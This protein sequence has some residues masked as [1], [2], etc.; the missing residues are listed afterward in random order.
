V[1]ENQALATALIKCQS[2]A[3]NGSL[4]L[5]YTLMVLFLQILWLLAKLSTCK[6]IF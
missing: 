6:N 5:S 2:N 1:Y 3:V 4:Q